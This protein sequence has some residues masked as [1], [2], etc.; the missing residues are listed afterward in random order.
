MPQDGLRRG[1]TVLSSLS[2]MRELVVL[3]FIVFIGGSILDY[4]EEKQPLRAVQTITLPNVQGY[5]DQMD[6]DVEGKRLFVPTVESGSLEVVDLVAGKRVRSIPGFKT[7]A[8]AWYGCE[9]N[10]LLVTSKGDGMVKVFREV[11]LDLIDSIKL[12]IDP[13]RIINDPR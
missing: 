13:N 1:Q 4:A 8:G 9:L 7:P 6:A 5:I 3:F 12:E 11:S 10:K 2:R